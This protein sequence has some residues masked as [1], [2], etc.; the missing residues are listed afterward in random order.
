M[1]NAAFE[2]LTD[3]CSKLKRQWSMEAHIVEY[4]G[5]IE[6]S[7]RCNLIFEAYSNLQ[8]YINLLFPDEEGFSR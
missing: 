7:K 5:N 4:G 8:M 2:E 6:D 1:K 3:M